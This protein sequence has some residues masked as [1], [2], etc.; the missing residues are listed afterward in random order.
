MNKN[1]DLSLD[2][3]WSFPEMYVPYLKKSVIYAEFKNN[4]DKIIEIKKISC[5]FRSNGFEPYSPST[6]ILVSIQPNSLEQIQIPFV[7]DMSL[8]MGT[9]TYSITASYKKV[10]SSK[11]TT[12]T[13][14]A[15]TR[16]IIVNPIRVTSKYFFISHKD[17]EDTDLAT[18]LDFYL[19]KIGLEGIV[20]ENDR[21]P[22]LDYWNEKIFPSID[23]CLA[24]IVIWTSNA[25]KD[26][27]NIFREVKYAKKNGK[28]II[29]LIERGVAIPKLFEN[30]NEYAWI[31]TNSIDGDLIQFVTDIEKNYEDTRYG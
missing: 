18:K 31:S 25:S 21:R 15:P 4:S 30:S 23:Y 14:E 8:P 13:Y 20:S 10:G 17:P 26:Y 7:A 19:R 12:V 11:S 24:L 5:Q 3:C 22:G 1:H 27:K 9:I 29:P 28:I 6:H 2:D 16:S